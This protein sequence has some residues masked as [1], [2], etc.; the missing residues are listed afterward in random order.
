MIEKLSSREERRAML[1]GTRY[2]GSPRF[3]DKR[4]SERE[5]E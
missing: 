1:V 4:A 2:R 5:N 3:F